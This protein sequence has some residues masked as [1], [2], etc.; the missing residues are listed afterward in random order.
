VL[1]TVGYRNSSENPTTTPN[2]QPRVVQ[3][4]MLADN[5]FV[6]RDGNG[7]P[8]FYEYVSSDGISWSA[9]EAAAR[10]RSYAGITGYLAT[11]T[12]Q[13]ENDF[14]AQRLTSNGW[15][16]GSDAAVEGAWRW[17]T[18]PELGAQFSS[19]GSVFGT[20]FRNWGSGE[21]NNSGSGENYAQM[22]ADTGKWNDLPNQPSNS[23]SNRPRGYLVEYSSPSVTDITFSKT[24]TISIAA[25]NDAPVLAS[26]SPSLAGMNEDDTTGAGQLVSSFVISNTISDVD[27]GATLGG[28]AITSLSSGNGIWQYRLNNSGS[29]LAMGSLSAKRWGSTGPMPLPVAT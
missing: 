25:G 17:E 23:D 26:A 19:A 5:M 1:R 13:A 14:I 22:R 15:I 28:I 18:G 29:W 20:A 12:T 8:H 9:A 16:G 7:L 2:G 24:F 6:R 4:E 11:I 27:T 3:V 21:P 10:S